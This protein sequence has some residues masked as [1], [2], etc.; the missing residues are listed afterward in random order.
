MKS[1][2][3]LYLQLPDLNENDI[4]KLL[5][6]ALDASSN[7]YLLLE[8]LL[9]WANSQ[10]GEIMFRPKN[11][12]VYPLIQETLEVLT[13]TIST[14]KININENINRDLHAYIDENMFKS[15]LR[16]LLTNC[17]KF[18]KNDGTIFIMADKKDGNIQFCIK[19]EGIGMSESELAMLFTKKEAYFIENKDTAK[20]SGLGLILC[21]EFIERHKGNI[22][23]E[24]QKG[25]GTTFYFTLPI[26]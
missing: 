14:K 5:N 9:T 15:V 11:A 13:Q 26:Q 17:I 16:N 23:A 7:T 22:W 4:N 2:L 6:A 8:N 19:D 1:I 25:I 20:G 3:E 21:K 24:S 18:S 12:I 10:R